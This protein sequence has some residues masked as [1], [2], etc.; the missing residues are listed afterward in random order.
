MYIFP[1]RAGRD[2][3]RQAESEKETP[4]CLTILSLYEDLVIYSTQA[5]V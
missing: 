1:V 3:V 4:T 2:V 5:N